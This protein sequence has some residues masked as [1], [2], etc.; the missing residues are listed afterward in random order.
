MPRT[1]LN[2]TFNN[3][4]A[5][6]LPRRNAGIASFRLWVVFSLLALA[7]FTN[8][9]ESKTTVFRGVLHDKTGAPIKGALVRIASNSSRAEAST[10]ADGTFHLPMVVP[11]KYQLSIVFGSKTAVYNKPIE[12]SGTSSA[13]MITLPKRGDLHLAPIIDKNSA[14]GGEE[15]SGQ[16]VSGLPLNKRDFSQLLLLAAGTMTDANGA[17]NFTQQFAINGQRGVEA[18]FAMDGADVSDPEMGGATFSN[19]NVDAVEQIESSSGWMP[20]EIGRGAAGFTNIHTRTGADGFHGSV[21]EFLRNSALDARNYFDFPSLAYPGRIPPFRRN[22][23]GFTNGGPIYIPHLCDGRKQTFYFIQYQAFRQV[24][25]TTQVMPV[26]TSTER[27]GVDINSALNDTFD[28]PIDP[29]IAAILA[30]YPLPNLPSGAYGAHTYATASKVAT[31]ANQFSLRIDHRLSPK[32]S[33]FARFSLDNITG[34]TTNPDQTAIE[35]SFGVQ[36]IDRQRNVMGSYT[37]TASSHLIFESL[38]SITRSTPGFPTPNRTDPAVKF[39]DGLFEAFN[40]AGGSVISAY[41]NLFHAQQTVGWSSNRH[42]IKAG[43]E[44]RV[45]RDTTYFGISPNG[46]YDFGGGVAYARGFIPSRSGKHDIRPGDPLPDTLS[47]F[48]SGSPFVYTAAI[49]PSYFSNGAHI[50][51]AAINRN[52]VAAYLE[53]TWK[54]SPTF[55]LD[56]GVRWELYTPITER[57][58]RTSSFLDIGGQQQFVVN[59]QPGYQTNK[60]SW[61]PRVQAAWQ[62]S[63]NLRAHAGGGITVIPPNIWQDNFLTGSTP[64]VVYPHL[65]S[66]TGSPIPYGFQITPA[67]LPKAYTPTGQDIFASGRT[68]TVRPNTVIDIDR[69]EKDVAALTPSHVVSALNLSGIDRS[70]GNGTLYTW[71]AG[72]EQRVGPLTANASYVGTTSVHLPRTSFPNAYPGASPGFAPHTQFDSSGAVIGGFGVENLITATAHSTYHAL[73][74]A[75]SGTIGHGGPGIQASYT[76]GKSIDDTSQVVGGTSST[77]AVVQG[78]PQNPYDTQPEKG[79]SSFDVTHAFTLS[80]AQDLHLESVSF[81]DFANTRITRGW[82]LLSI[83]T[84]TSGSPFTVYSGI[85]QTGYGSNGVDRPDQIA[86]PN[87]STSRP[88]RE[89]YFGRGSNNQ[90]FFNIPIG[91]SGGTGPNQG[92]FGTLGRNTFRGPAFYNFDFALI[93]DTPFGQRSG[94]SEFVNVQ[95]RAEFFNLFNIVTMGLPANILQGSGFGEISKT[96]GNSRQIQFSIKLIY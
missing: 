76:W 75:L 80:G 1:P 14:T 54:I 20:A 62:V 6:L 58:L 71:T 95:F 34:P 21:F 33:F 56:L 41:G 83:S 26:P 49:A 61:G 69:Y 15:L 72:L 73:Q 90:S 50:G 68:D 9:Q 45:N 48:L 39:N 94:G 11:G 43:V 52:A 36:Y 30:R 79:P 84:I 93:K 35:P 60:N 4:A 23:F 64:F 17:T 28:V 65:Q 27:T 59:P 5:S 87:L 22:E 63:S 81:L 12:A 74:T 18:V 67:Q 86:R 78:F 55:T 91:V 37:H 25:G 70:F 29:G 88:V 89:D 38:F 42:A 2:K 7:T 53:D 47:G 13:V 3:R 19:F 10:D 46:E 66:A 82:E 96:A 40:S 92:R 24:L 85:Q 16:T 77:G 8:A 57:A 51:P 44:M 31:T 32:D